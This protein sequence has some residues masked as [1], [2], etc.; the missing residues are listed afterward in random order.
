MLVPLGDD[1]MKKS[2]RTYLILLSSVLVTTVALAAGIDHTRMVDLDYD[3]VLKSKNQW[4]SKRNALNALESQYGLTFSTAATVLDDTNR[5]A[6]G[7]D[8]GPLV[9]LYEDSGKSSKAFYGAERMFAWASDDQATTSWYPQGITGSGDSISGGTI[10]GKRALL[11]SWYAKKN[12]HKGA[13]I[14][15]VDVTNMND[16]RYRHVLL[17]EPYTSGGTANFRAVRTH[18][19][20]LAWYKNLLY[21]ADTDGIR[22]FDTNKIMRAQANSAKDTIGIHN[23]KA[24]AYDYRYILPQVNQYTSEDGFRY[25]FIALDRTGSQH[26][27]LAGEF[28]EDSSG[29]M[30]HFDINHTSGRLRESDSYAYSDDSKRIRRT[31]TNGMVSA[32]GHYFYNHTYK[33]DQY[34]IHI[35]K[36]NGYVSIRGGYGLE[37]LYYD[38]STKR[39]WFHTEFPGGREV[40]YRDDPIANF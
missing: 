21:V 2:I 35:Q 28:Q 15:F 16:V 3:F 29:R 36:P 38:K 5:R 17:V 9:S 1:T 33:R 30:T 27:L 25:S 7:E 8:Y 39:L 20:G 34:R 4:S 31:V 19:G 40:F 6:L 18:A 10:D 37:D 23:G 12:V 24:Y 13:R 22:V 11:V 14:S 32:H 26:T